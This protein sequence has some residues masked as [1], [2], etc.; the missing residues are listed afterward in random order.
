M[1][2]LAVLARPPKILVADDDWLTRDLLQTYLTNA[3]CE[4]TT[5]ADGEQAWEA[6]QANI[7]DLALLDS[8]YALDE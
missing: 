8:H 6:A 1:D 3:G 5:V 2:L 4:V 7:P